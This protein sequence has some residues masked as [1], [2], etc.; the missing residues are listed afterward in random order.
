LIDSFLHQADRA[1][2]GKS[3]SVQEIIAKVGEI[4]VVAEK[5]ALPGV[6][7]ED[8]KHKGVRTHHHPHPEAPPTAF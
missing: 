4:K 5:S 2:G 1:N 3:R 6:Q 7:I 8:H